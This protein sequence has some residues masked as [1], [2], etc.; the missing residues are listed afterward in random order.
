MYFK[1]ILIIKTQ[2]SSSPDFSRVSSRHL[3][4]SR[5]LQLSRYSSQTAV[6]AEKFGKVCV[7]V[8]VCVFTCVGVRPG[9]CVF[10]LCVFCKKCVY[11]VRFPFRFI[12]RRW[13]RWTWV[14]IPV[15]ISLFFLC[16]CFLFRP[17]RTLKHCLPSIVFA[18]LFRRKKTN[19]RA[20]L[21]VL[22]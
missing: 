20:K 12:G 8:C 13:Y 21:C 3:E 9:E 2:K 18:K 14:Q 19:L 4:S 15:N 11:Y 5:H 16:V 6:P 22:Q 17:N 10:Y 7:C 1:K